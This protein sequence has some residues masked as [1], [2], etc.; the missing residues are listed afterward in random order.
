MTL[1]KSL[2]IGA[3]CL[4]A[5]GFVG[6]AHAQYAPYPYPAYPYPAYP[7]AYPYAAY[8]APTPISPAQAYPPSWSYDPYT[9]GQAPCPQKRPGDLE[10]CS[11]IMPPTYGQPSYW[12]R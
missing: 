8:P 2:T 9:S 5:A 10:T 6:A 3:V 1:A 11:Q 12:S 7:A 4:A